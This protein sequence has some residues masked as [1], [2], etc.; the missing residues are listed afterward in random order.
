[1]AKHSS[2]SS[3]ELSDSP[4]KPVDFRGG[5]SSSSVSLETYRRGHRAVT[6]T[7]VFFFTILIIL[8]LLWAFSKLS[9]G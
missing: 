1:M 2:S 7:M 8:G 4:R 9:G 6:I 3:E 5:N